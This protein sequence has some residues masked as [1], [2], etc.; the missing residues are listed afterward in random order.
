M[1][2][3]LRAQSLLE[4]CGLGTHIALG[5]Q[6]CAGGI[7]KRDACGQLADDLAID[8]DLD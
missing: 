7:A 1:P 5:H 8:L 3:L 2:R 6:D 4:K